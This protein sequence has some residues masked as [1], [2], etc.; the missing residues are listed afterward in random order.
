V[1]FSAVGSAYSLSESEVIINRL[2]TETPIPMAISATTLDS[3]PAA[4][5]APPVSPEDIQ[6]VLLHY[7]PA[8]REH[9]V[10]QY[11]VSEDQAADWIQSFVLEK[12]LQ[13]DLIA[14]ADDRRSLLL[15]FLLRCLDHFVI[16]ELR[17]QHGQ[18]RFPAAGLVPLDVVSELDLPAVL[19]RSEA[20]SDVAWARHLI[21]E[22]LH[23]MH[24]HCR[25]T[26]RADIWEVFECRILKPL[27]EQCDP[28]PYGHLAERFKLASQK[29]AAQLLITA[30]RMFGRCLRAVIGEYAKDPQMIELEIQELKEI[31]V[32]QDSHHETVVQRLGK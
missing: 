11:G 23:L 15:T 2:E 14:K 3:N 4:Q 21:K 25:E 16:Q 17:R 26:G 5:A 1:H 12:I 24:Q 29:H 32:R 30:K 6:G 7:L 20:E 31:L 8:L 13:Q 28:M 27:F 10:K 9:V 19:E 22:S 18:K